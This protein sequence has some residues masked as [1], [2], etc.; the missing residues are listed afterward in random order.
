MKETDKKK[1]SNNQTKRAGRIDRRDHKP[2]Q[3]NPS[4][5]LKAKEARSSKASALTS[6]SSIL[7]SDSNVGTEPSEV[8]ENLVI[9]YLDDVNRFEEAPQ[10]LKANAMV[11]KENMDEVVANSSIDLEK[12]AKKGKEEVSDS[13][14]TQRNKPQSKPLHSTPKKPTN[15][16]KEPS[17]VVPK[18]ISNNGSQ[19]VKFPS[20]PSS[21]SSG[22]VDDRPVEEVKEV[23]V[24]DGASNGAHSIG[25]DSETVDSEESDEHEVEAALEQKI[26]EMEMRIEKLEEELREVAALEISLYSVIPEHGSSAHK[27][28]APAR[29]LSRLY[30]H[31]C[32]HWSLDKRATVAKNTVSGLVLIAKSC[33]NDVP[34]YV[35]YNLTALKCSCK[36]VLKSKANKYSFLLCLKVNLLVDQHCCVERDHLTG[37]WQFPP[38]Q[39]NG[40]VC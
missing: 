14:S 3:E 4:K 33:S 8:Y 29:R 15:L 26:E 6:D 2:H 32:K 18:I 27:V 30:L 10:D 11:S 12:D 19:N 5:T 20:E 23:D 24:L 25:N 28:H 7:V 35:S 13:E 39:S 16:T 31:S 34:R 17:N 9:H 38:V 40:K 1:I 22:E 37:I 21:E 36:I